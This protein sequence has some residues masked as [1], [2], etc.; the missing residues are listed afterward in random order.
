MA[1]SWEVVSSFSPSIILVAALQLRV[2]P[3]AF[4][5]DVRGRLRDLLGN[6]IRILLA[7]LGGGLIERL[8]VHGSLIDISNAQ[9]NDGHERGCEPDSEDHDA[10]RQAIGLQLGASLSP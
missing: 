6:R 2:E 7:V 5:M 3:L 9:R 8:R 4:D 1:T 10:D